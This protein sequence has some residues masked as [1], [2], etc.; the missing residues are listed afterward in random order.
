MKLRVTDGAPY[1]LSYPYVD[2]TLAHGDTFEVGGEKGAALL[3]AH[4][5]LEEIVDVEGGEVEDASDSDDGLE[6]LTYDELRDR[7]TEAEIDGRGSMNKDELIAALLGRTA[8]HV[9]VQID[10]RFGVR[11]LCEFSCF[12]DLSLDVL[13]FR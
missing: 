10:T 6:D 13:L 9:G 7:A 1:N 8:N 4:D 11:V 12:L 2:G 3:D 5:Y